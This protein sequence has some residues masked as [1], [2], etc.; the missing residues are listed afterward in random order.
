T[1]TLNATRLTFLTQFG[2][3]AVPVAFEILE[4]TDVEEGLLRDVVVLTGS[5]L[6]ERF[7][8]LI[9]RNGGA[10]HAGELLSHVG[11][12]GE[13][14]LDPAGPVD[15]DLVFFRQFVDTEDRDD[16]LQFL[17]LLQDRLH[18]VRHPVVILTDVLRVEDPG[19]RGERVHRGVQTPGGDVTRE[20]GRRI[21][22]G[23]RRR[24]CWVGVVVRGNVDRLQRG[25][26]VAPGRGDPFLQ[27]T[28]L[29]G[30]VGLVTHRRG[31]PPQQRG[32]FL[33]RLGEA[34]DV[35]DE[36]QHVLVLHVPEVLRH[37][38]RRERDAQTGPGWFVHL[39][40]DERGLVEHAGF[41]HLVDQV[42]PLPGT[43][44]HPGEH[45]HTTVVLGHALNHFLDQHGL[46]HTGTT[47]ETDLPTL[48][49]RGEQVDDLDPGL[50]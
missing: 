20:F 17:V 6:V 4:A 22:V 19:G 25:D 49:V 48:Y 2:L 21:Q 27:L 18:R 37:R 39:A 46:A 1:S 13:E 42:V 29:I 26:R 43:L 11:V 16:V 12:L 31:H 34:E 3:D 45:G 40:E 35:V 30:K 32:Y 23:E 15:G 8:G 33:A 28:H 50:E 38:Q 10:H 36:Q 44:P 9:Q 24:G 5:D 41:F 14:L 7:D 47:E